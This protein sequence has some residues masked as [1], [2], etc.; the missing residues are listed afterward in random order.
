MK[1]ITILLF[2]WL[3]S[4]STFASADSSVIICYGDL[5]FPTPCSNFSSNSKEITAAVRGFD[6]SVI[7]A[8]CSSKTSIGHLQVKAECVQGDLCRNE[9]E[10]ERDLVNLLV[11]VSTKDSTGRISFQSSGCKTTSLDSPWIH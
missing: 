3:V 11:A 7:A 9:N 2:T 5:Q 10:A 1:S 4:L 6:L 8:G